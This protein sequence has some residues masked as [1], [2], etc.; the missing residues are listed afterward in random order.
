MT[1]RAHLHRAGK[2]NSGRLRL[3]RQI[4]LQAALQ[5]CKDRR[6]LRAV[7]LTHRNVVDIS[8]RGNHRRLLRKP[9]WR[10]QSLQTGLRHTKFP[11]AGKRTGNFS[12]FEAFDRNRP[13]KSALNEIFAGDFPTH[14]NREFIYADREFESIYQGIPALGTMVCRAV[15]GAGASRSKSFLEP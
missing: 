12:H 13:P 5:A 7:A 2:R 3:A 8:G 9:W 4:R 6:R 1:P 14:R 11:L 10:R 15:R